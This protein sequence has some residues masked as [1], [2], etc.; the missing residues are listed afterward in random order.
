M[1]DLREKFDLAR[2]RL[3]DKLGLPAAS[4]APV[5]PSA[6]SSDD[7][8]SGLSVLH[9]VLAFEDSTQAADVVKPLDSDVIPLPA[10]LS[11]SLSGTWRQHL[12]E[13]GKHIWQRDA[14]AAASN[15]VDLFQTAISS[16]ST[17]SLPS[18]LNGA[19]TC[20]LLMTQQSPGRYHCIQA[21]SAG[22]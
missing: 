9:R 3:R 15:E 17:Q 21:C 8:D 18:P 5:E 13:D 20:R 6:A 2:K 12:S 7:S 16:C 4:P 14:R 22:C 1:A 10:A 11:H 19:Y